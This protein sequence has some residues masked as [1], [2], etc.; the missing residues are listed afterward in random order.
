MKESEKRR[1]SGVR[2]TTHLGL[3]VMC[4]GL[5]VAG[6]ATLIV[7]PP[8]EAEMVRFLPDVARG[9]FGGAESPALTV[10][11][12]GIETL[13]GEAM[14]AKRVGMLFVGALVL[15]L[16][17]LLGVELCGSLPGLPA[18][19]V[20]LLVAL[21]PMV[22]MQSLL[23]HPEMLVMAGLMGALWLFLRERHPWGAVAALGAGLSV[24]AGA[25]VGLALGGWLCREGRWRRG[26]PYVAAGLGAGVYWWMKREAPGMLGLSSSA[27]EA[28]R[29]LYFLLVGHGHWIAVAGMVVAWRE[30][31]LDRRR[32]R[33]ALLV[34]AGF[35]LIQLFPGRGVVERG[36]MPVTPLLFTA[37]VAGLF[38]LRPGAKWV[39]Y[40]ALAGLLTAGHFVNPF[41]WPFAYENNLTF[42]SDARLRVRAA[43]WLEENAAGKGVATAGP[44]AVALKEPKWGYVQKPMRVLGLPEFDMAALE[45][46]REASPDVFVMYSHEWDPPANLLRRRVFAWAAGRFLGMREPLDPGL[47]ESKLGMQRK[48][49]LREGRLWAEVYMR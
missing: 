15:Y 2:W 35:V 13:A 39:W 19:Y 1:R 5:V 7:L 4:L 34:A 6:H 3:A 28:G 38:V 22:Y 26:L 18:V 17:F 46:A 43:K 40:G 12:S 11:L 42:A 27:F 21:S 49:F 33:V 29:L 44:L 25:W 10:W 32:W 47:L 45:A 36:L 30:G 41:F 31:V 24:A 48:A 8:G 16:T 9:P 23:A 37:G 20:L 14:W